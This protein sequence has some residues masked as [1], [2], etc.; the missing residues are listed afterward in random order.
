MESKAKGSLEEEGVTGARPWGIRNL[1]KEG[2][3]R[4]LMHARA[5][6]L[7]DTQVGS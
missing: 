1:A 5:A 2:V 3:R 6:A 7:H 4:D